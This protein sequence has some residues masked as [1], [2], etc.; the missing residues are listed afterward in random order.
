[1]IARIVIITFS[2]SCTLAVLAAD[3]DARDIPVAP[4]DATAGPYSFLRQL[5]DARQ[6][7]PIGFLYLDMRVLTRSLAQLRTNAPVQREQQQV[8]ARL[9]VLIEM[10]E[11]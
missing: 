9:D 8:I 5:T 10:L 6:R 11:K 7:D 3:E 2:F 1:M 4:L